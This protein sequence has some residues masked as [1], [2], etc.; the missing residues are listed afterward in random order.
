MNHYDQRNTYCNKSILRSK[1]GMTLVELICAMVIGTILIGIASAYI[2]SAMHLFGNVERNA[3]KKEITD[4]TAGYIKERLLYAKNIWVVE[5]DTP[6]TATEGRQVLFIGDEDG[7]VTATDGY[8]FSI[9]ESDTKPVNVYGEDLY[10][11]FKISLDFNI[12][13]PDKAES[14]KVFGFTVHACKDGKRSY[15]NKRTF[16]LVNAHENNE[17]TNSVSISGA[18]K[19][20]YLIFDCPAEDVADSVELDGDVQ[21][22]LTWTVPKTGKYKIQTWG[23]DSGQVPLQSSDGTMQLLVSLEQ[24][25]FGGYAAGT[26]TLKKGTV[27]Y[28]KAGGAGDAQPLDSRDAVIKGG[29]NGGGAGLNVSTS[30]SEYQRGVGG[31]GASDVRV[32]KDDLYNRIIVAGGG[33]GVCAFKKYNEGGN[34]GGEQGVDGRNTIDEQRGRTKES[35]RGGTQNAPGINNLPSGSQGVIAASFGKGASLERC[36]TFYSAGG[37][38]GWYGGGAGFGGGGGGSSYVLTASSY[39]PESYF[40]ENPSYYFSD[41]INATKTDAKYAPKP[42]TGNNGFVRITPA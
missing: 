26:V 39:K 32:L 40:L 21:K 41:I 8:L 5:S 7:N 22:E 38:G 14:P 24:N 17:P 42:T 25:G 20:Y 36:K 19:K 4:R 33:G 12:N 3:E 37:G 9:G 27:L 1:K 30:F 18:N 34:A 13:V 23:G 15:S 28:L 6:P 11:Q 29:F 16:E 2:I 31:G 10:R 35:G